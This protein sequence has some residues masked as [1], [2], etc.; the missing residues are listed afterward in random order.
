LRAALALAERHGLDPLAQGCRRA[1][2][3]CAA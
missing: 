1:L 3:S 2:Q